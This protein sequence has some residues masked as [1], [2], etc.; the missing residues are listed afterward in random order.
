MHFQNQAIIGSMGYRL[1]FE[2]GLDFSS[3][4]LHLSGPHLFPLGS[5]SKLS[6]KFSVALSWGLMAE[7]G[8]FQVGR[9]W[10]EGN[11]GGGGIDRGRACANVLHYVTT[12]IETVGKWHELRLEPLAS[13]GSWG[14]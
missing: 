12:G 14:P 4:E 1:G 8:F 5:G 11:M 6:P 9:G 2:V 10:K 7:E 3:K 13:Q